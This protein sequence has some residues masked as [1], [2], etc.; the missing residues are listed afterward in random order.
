MTHRLCGSAIPVPAKIPAGGKYQPGTGPGVDYQAGNENVGWPCLEL[1]LTQPQ[2]YQ[3]SYVTG[4]GTGKSGATASGF[5]ASARG[6]LDGTGVTSL[7]ARGAT[8]RNGQVVL[9]TEM[10]IENEFE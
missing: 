8:V 4:V 3:Y 9:S 7:F 2:Y 6:D 5:E 1:A 10:Y